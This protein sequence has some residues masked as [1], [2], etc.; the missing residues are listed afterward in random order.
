[1]SVLFRSE[2]IVS[3]N[4]EPANTTQLSPA[5]SPATPLPSGV[6]QTGSTGTT[7]P[8]SVK[9]RS[10]YSGVGVMKL[11]RK[12]STGNA[13]AGRSSVVPVLT[14]ETGFQMSSKY[15]VPGNVMSNV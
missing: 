7:N 13:P 10:V 2:P 4:G 6:P 11:L 12:S 5:E 1:M 3:V 9:L 15:P 8:S 14:P